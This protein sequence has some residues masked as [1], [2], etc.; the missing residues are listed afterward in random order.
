MKKILL[1][2]TIFLFTNMTFF[3]GGSKCP[4]KGD[5]AK[6]KLQ[7]LDTLKNRSTI[8]NTVVK[9]S[10]DDVMK[11]GDDTKRFSENTFVDVTGYVFDV[12]Y[13]GAETCNCHTTDK[14]QLDIH[15]EIV[16]DL[17]HPDKTKRMIVEINRFI[18][19]K[20]PNMDY[21]VVK[22]L[23]G[24]K[25]ELTGWL[26]FDEEHK[27]NAINTKPDGTNVWRGTCWEVHPCMSIKEVK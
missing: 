10:L 5:S 24:K 6:E 22:L 23:K 27:Q 9:L 2:L 13:G 7:N 11:P 4:P 19:A 21:N 8:S 15:I 18:R 25:V 17:A 14:T 3:D 1:F 20:D 26:F 12:K 16:Q